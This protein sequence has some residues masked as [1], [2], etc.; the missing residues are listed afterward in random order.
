MTDVPEEM[1]KSDQCAEQDTLK[2]DET[3]KSHQTESSFNLT[4]MEV[5]AAGVEFRKKKKKK[6]S[7]EDGFVSSLGSLIQVRVT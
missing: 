2:D 7:E 1:D 5:H 6:V 4:K 3:A